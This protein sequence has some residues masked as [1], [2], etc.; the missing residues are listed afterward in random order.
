MTVVLR[1]TDV[2][3]PSR[4]EYWRHVLDGTLGPLEVRQPGGLD[5]RDQLRLGEA[6]VVRV[7][8]LSTGRPGGASRTGR[9]IRRSD[10]DVCKVDVLARGRGVVQQDGR[11]AELGPGDL[12]LVD[13]SRPVRWAMSPARVVAVVFPRALLPLPSDEVAR[14]TAVRIPG[15]QG[16]A[17]LAS[18]LARQLVGPLD[19]A[20]DGTRLGTAVLDL[21]TVALAARARRTGTVAPD[22]QRRVLLQRVH[23]YIEQH[24]GDP[25]LAP[26]TIAAAHH[27]SV[28]YLY[29]LFEAQGQGVAGQ[30]RRRRLERCRRDLLDPGLHARPVSAIG[31]R[32]GLPDPASFS[33]AFRDAYGVP[34]SEY[35]AGG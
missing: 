13:L 17:A 24:L 12:T 29:K 27:V 3:V 23:A 14:L 15:D 16:P 28:R 25:G 30:V 31:A 20:A 1:A 18:T 4:M 21:L 33:R 7:G 22:S 26:E 8:E 5:V 11:E 19:D 9:H 32:W 6:G 2:P 35:R 34:P 10:L